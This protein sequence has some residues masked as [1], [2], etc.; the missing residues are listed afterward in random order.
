MAIRAILPLSFGQGHSFDNT[1]HALQEL[2]LAQKERT[3]RSRKLKSSRKTSLVV[4]FYPNLEKFCPG[5]N[6]VILL[7]GK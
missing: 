3:V 6:N 7:L 5:L 1:I 2:R 4:N